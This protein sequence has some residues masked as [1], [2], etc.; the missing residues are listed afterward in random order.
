MQPIQ[1]YRYET[2]AMGGMRR[3]T[4]SYLVFTML[5]QQRGWN[6][7]EMSKTYVGLPSRWKTLMK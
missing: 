4:F 3:K 5:Q 7:I 2:I 1:A 6:E